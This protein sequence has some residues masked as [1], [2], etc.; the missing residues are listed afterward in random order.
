[1]RRREFITLVA[2]A[3]AW[4]LGARARQSERIQ[5][6]VTFS[7]LVVGPGVFDMVMGYLQYPACKR[8]LA[9]REKATAATRGFQITEA[10]L[11]GERLEAR[12]T[13]L[14][15]FGSYRAAHSQAIRGL[16]PMVPIETSLGNVRPSSCAHC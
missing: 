5:A 13:K 9:R 1:M 15:L 11:E 16:H 8:T 12:L 3:A 10:P 4:P 2:G 7:T 14:E 6:G